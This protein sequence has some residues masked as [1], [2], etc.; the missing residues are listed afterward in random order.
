VFNAA[1]GD[2]QL[3]VNGVR[4]NSVGHGAVGVDSTTSIRIGN[5]TSTFPFGGVI[6]DV[7]VYQGVLNDRE[8]ANS[9]AG[10]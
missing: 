7:H 2:V 8:I 9:Y 6:D 3:Y 5:K 10:S 4:Q 1:T